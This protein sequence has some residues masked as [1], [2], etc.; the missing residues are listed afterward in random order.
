MAVVETASFTAA[1]LRLHATQSGVSQRIAKLEHQLKVQLF[2]R[3][4]PRRYG[5][6]SWQA[7]VSASFGNL[8]VAQ[9]GRNRAWFICRRA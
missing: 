5:N 2:L 1:A 7:V 4:P 8:G 3:T 6:A 9:R